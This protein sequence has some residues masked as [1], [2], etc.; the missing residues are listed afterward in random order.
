MNKF[1]RTILLFLFILVLLVI[2]PNEVFG[3][4][5]PSFDKTSLNYIV[6]EKTEVDIL[7]Q[8]E[9]YYVIIPDNNNAQFTNNNNKNYD[10][11]LDNECIF[12]NSSLKYFCILKNS[13]NHNYIYKITS[14]YLRNS[15][16][17]RAP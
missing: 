5:T 15:V 11:G 1:L 6:N 10:L 13:S 4:N 16:N 3:C 9:Q 2:N 8:S 17:T 14:N 7:E 12:S